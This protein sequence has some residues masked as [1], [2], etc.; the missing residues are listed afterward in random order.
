MGF[1][2]DYTFTSGRPNSSATYIWVLEDGRGQQT[3][4]RINAQS[5]G[6]LQTFVTTWK[7]DQKPFKSYVA[8]E[9]GGQRTMI[10]N[11]IDMR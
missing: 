11:K 1:S 10:S 2:V 4:L 8:E 7:P 6:T 5:Q 9:R 3:L